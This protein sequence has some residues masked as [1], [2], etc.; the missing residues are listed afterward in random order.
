[1]N[2]EGKPYADP[3]LAGVALGLVLLTAFVV[4]GRGLGASGAFAS[5]AASTVDVVAS[6][7]AH[8]NNFFADH[9]DAGGPLREWL[10]VE[11]AGVLVG[12]WLSAKLAHWSSVRARL[13]EWTGAHALVPI[14]VRLSHSMCST[15]RAASCRT[16]WSKRPS[17]PRALCAVRELE[18]ERR[19]RR[20]STRREIA[21][22][23]SSPSRSGQPD[24][25]TRSI[26]RRAPQSL[27]L[28]LRARQHAVLFR[29]PTSRLRSPCPRSFLRHRP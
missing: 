17:D 16:P 19:W 8:N 28:P 5:V 6:T 18:G 23:R 11:L 29:P 7:S 10:V 3:Y 13:H 25:L 21:S 26:P 2:G 22:S 24:F 15:G 14:V 27:S 4:V 12:A 1:M 9:L 20:R